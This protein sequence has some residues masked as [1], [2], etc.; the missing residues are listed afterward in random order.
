LTKAQLFYED[1]REEEML[2]LAEGMVVFFLFLLVFALNYLVSTWHKN[3]LHA[4]AEVWRRYEIYLEDEQLAQ[5][6]LDEVRRGIQYEKS[7]LEA[8]LACRLQNS[9]VSS[10]LERSEYW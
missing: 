3:E 10:E 5:W 4:Q 6:V 1:W 9:P 8:L 7:E 2:L